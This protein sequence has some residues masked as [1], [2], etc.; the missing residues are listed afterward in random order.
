MSSR[1]P[2]VY[3]VDDDV[4]VCRALSLLLKSHG[5]KVQTFAR[6]TDFLHFKHPKA[7][8]CLVLDLRLPSMSGLTLQETMAL[9]GQIMPIIFISGYG[10]I[11]KSVKAMKGGGY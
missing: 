9:R 7:P 10:D 6:A 4:S 3:V 11:P 1:K 2:V 8:S 5:F